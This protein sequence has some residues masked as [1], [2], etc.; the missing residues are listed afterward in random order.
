MEA[1][2]ADE[3]VPAWLRGDGAV[4]IA[5]GLFV[6][7]YLLW[8]LFAA[9]LL[10]VLWASTIVKGGALLCVLLYLPTLFDGASRKARGRP[11]HALRLWSAWRN[12]WRYL[13]LRL[14]REVPIAAGA[15]QIFCFCP[16]GI[17][18]RSR[19]GYRGTLALAAR[20]RFADQRDIRSATRQL[21]SRVVGYGGAW[22]ALF[23]GIECRVLA[24]SPMFALPLVRDICLARTCPRAA[25]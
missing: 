11:W 17:L 16:H 2:F 1:R 19:Y 9:V 10:W 8:P 20:L 7:S 14:V 24:A 18:V 12:S 15:R 21:M 5:F 3:D 25:L 4:S 23:P 22:E 13:K 6:S